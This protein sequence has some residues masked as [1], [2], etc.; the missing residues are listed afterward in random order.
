MCLTR[1]LQGTASQKIGGTVWHKSVA[2]RFPDD[3]AD[4]L[5]QGTIGEGAKRQSLTWKV[6]KAKGAEE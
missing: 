6:V 3:Y 1:L 5:E 4:R 2:A